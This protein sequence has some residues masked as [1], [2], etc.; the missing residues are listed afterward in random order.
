MFNPFPEGTVLHAD[1]MV[2]LSSLKKN[3]DNGF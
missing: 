3:F 2:N 1:V